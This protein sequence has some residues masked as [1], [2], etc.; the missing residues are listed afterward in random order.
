MRFDL[1]VK[2]GLLVDGSGAPPRRAD[3]GVKDGVVAE[4]GAL[5]GALAARAV[6]ADGALVTPGFVDIHTHYDGQVSWDEELSP[7]IAH[8]VTTC[9]MGNCGVGFAPVR[10]R[11]RDRLIDLVQGVEDIPGTVL[12]EGLRWGWESFAEYMDALDRRPHA[13]D[14]AAQ[15]PHDALRVFVMGE[16]ASA[17]E[18]AS[19]ADVE[20]MRRLLREALLAGAV[21]FSTGRTDNH[22]GADGA[23][24]P[25]AEAD[26][27]E[28]AGLARAFAGLEHGVLQAVS[29]F[30]MARSP[31]R[32]DPEFDVLEA[33]ARASGRPLSISL[34]QRAGASDQ[35]R[36]I[37]ARVE[38][39]DARGLAMRVQVAPR[40]IGVLLGLEASFHPFMGFPSYKAVAHL[41][42]E[43]RVAALR[44]PEVKAR[45]LGESSEPLAGDGSP[46]PPLADQLLANL[47]F[48]AMSLFRLGA[49]PDYEPARQTSLYGEALRRGVPTLSVVYDAMLEDEGRALLYFPIYNYGSGTLSEVSEMLHHPLALLGLSDGGAHV[50]TTCDASFPTFL[51]THWARDRAEGRLPVERAVQMLTAAPARWMGFSDRG[52][53]VPGRRAD[54]NVIDHGRLALARPTLARDLPR[55]GRRFVQDAAG[56][57]ATV[58]RG[59]IVREEGRTTGARPG[60]LLRGRSPQ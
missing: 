44:A 25:A 30:D 10:P 48:V 22:R 23:E 19:P 18:A 20:A 40:G 36:R 42:L 12:H 58:V 38:Q 60:R 2:N 32:F 51:L 55:G 47:D 35:W 50:G 31:E 57:R 43:E 45:M 26:A 41:P 29:D 16:R 53:L 59:E 52:L 56:Y 13:I 8:G 6:D 27:A 54:L 14:F 49:A 37:L 7:S 15:V 39:A 46:I 5:S 17:R 1:L 34:L 4:V 28:L 21:G 11:D 9:V 3:V 33:M 24:T